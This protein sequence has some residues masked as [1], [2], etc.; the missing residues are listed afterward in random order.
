MGAACHGDG[1]AVAVEEGIAGVLVVS[2]GGDTW[3]EG[4]D[5]FSLGKCVAG[6]S[7]LDSSGVQFLLC[8]AAIL[9]QE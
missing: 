4:V 5:K 1:A 9:S 6:V 2:T 3:P 7:I 8:G